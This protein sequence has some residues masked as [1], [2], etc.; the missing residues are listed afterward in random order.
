MIY[1]IYYSIK[2]SGTILELKFR[3]IQNEDIENIS[4]FFELRSNKTCDSVFLDVFL[5]KDYYNV[6]FATWENKALFL[7][8]EIDGKI[9]A[10]LPMCREK[11]LKPAF[12]VLQNYFNKI[13]KTKLEIFLGDEESVNILHLNRNEFKVFELEDARD[14]IY[15]AEALKNLS[16]KKLRKKKNHINSFIRENEGNF[17]YKQLCCKNESEIIQFLDNWRFEKGNDVEEHLDGEIH[18]IKNILENCNELKVIMAGVYVN[19]KLEAFTIGTYNKVERMAIIHIEKANSNIRG[20]YPYINQ[21]FIINAFPQAN[22]VN[23]EDDLGIDGLRKAKLSYEPLFFA[24]KYRI[25]EI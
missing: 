15:S 13:L 19:N 16:G 7:T 22:I 12:F 23:R 10:T 18:G 3:E 11:Q 8:M 20:L 9:Y 4:S 24:K 17:F 21:Q 25:E 6:K 1:F 5:W 2:R 14:Y